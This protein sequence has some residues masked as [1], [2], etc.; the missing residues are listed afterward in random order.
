MKSAT[1]I[2]FLLASLLMVSAPVAKAAMLVA[3]ATPVAFHDAMSDAIALSHQYANS[4][5]MRVSGT[6]M[7]PYFGTGT[8]IVVKPISADHLRKGMIVVYRNRFGETVAH[9]LVGRTAAGWVAKGY[10]N[11]EP[12]STPVNASDLIGVVYATFNTAGAIAANTSSL[13]VAMAAPAR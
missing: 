2:L 4:T 3:P 7:L 1:R 10:N 11:T 6:S 13:S 9:R 12:D 8:L 5:V